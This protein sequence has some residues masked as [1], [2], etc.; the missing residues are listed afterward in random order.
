[1]KKVTTITLI[2][3]FVC[4]IVSTQA[5]KYKVKRG[6]IL[7][8]KEPIGSV[9][10]KFGA[11]VSADLQFKN[12]YKE[13]FLIVKE[14]SYKLN[15]PNFKPV[16]WYTLEFPTHSKS[17]ILKKESS[18]SSERKFITHE[19]GRL[20]VHLYKEGIR[21]E[22]L[23]KF[24]DYAEQLHKD[25]IDQHQ[26]IEAHKNA[27]ASFEPVTDQSKPVRFLS[28][29][30]EDGV[31]IIQ[32]LNNK[33]YRIIGKY[34]HTYSEG[35]AL[36]FGKNEIVIYKKMPQK[37]DFNGKSTDFIP[38]GFIDLD[39]VASLFIYQEC[40]EIS[41]SQL[42]LGNEAPSAARKAV[43]YMVARRLL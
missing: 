21:K 33:K 17:I 22:D 4:I 27:L 18:I 5:Q 15:Y 28:K 31:L 19:L 6:T 32:P 34:I 43:D 36:G 13:L 25:T 42:N 11:F 29:E 7:K 35:M 26:L 23:L 9:E 8:D 38:A 1:M 30:G 41:S 12:L 14:G 20:E 40:K 3:L 16:F 24:K 2:V 10:G 39:V 37:I